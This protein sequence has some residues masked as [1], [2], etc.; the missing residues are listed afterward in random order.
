VTRI[1]DAP[2]DSCYGTLM[3]VTY[4]PPPSR[5]GFL[6][7]IAEGLVEAA[8]TLLVTLFARPR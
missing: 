1:T 6:T 4:D 5:P 7:R 2:A 3:K 8:L